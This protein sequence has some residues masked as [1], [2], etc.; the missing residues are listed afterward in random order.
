M[1][2]EVNEQGNYVTLIEEV[3]GRK[4]ETNISIRDFIDSITAS[5]NNKKLKE[6]ESPIF[7]EVGYCRLIKWKKLNRSSEIY[8]ICRKRELAPTQ[9]LETFIGEVGYP[10]L[11][12]GIK[13]VNNKV[14]CLYVV[15][16]KEE[17]IN[18]NT[19]IYQYPYTNVSSRIG[20]VCLGRNEFEKDVRENNYLYEIP[21]LFFSMPNSL[22]SYNKLNNK[23]GFECSE[24]MNFHKNK[25][26]DEKLLVE[27]IYCRNFKQ[28]FNDL[29]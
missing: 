15:A 5:S 1:L 8:V 12:F 21:N 10:Q 6:V 13:V 28:W 19:K 14:S 2:F 29:K 26:Y 22:H 4:T 24:L 7:K 3:N 9:L 20:S 23:M 25:Q 11:L 16:T 18:E 17:E 27:N